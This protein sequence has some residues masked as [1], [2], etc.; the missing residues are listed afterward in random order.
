VQRVQRFAAP[1]L[2]VVN[3]WQIR[4]AALAAL[5]ALVLK[6]FFSRAYKRKSQ[7]HCGKTVAANRS[8]LRGAASAASAAPRKLAKCD[9]I[10]QDAFK[11]SSATL[12]SC[13]QK[14][15]TY[16]SV[17]VP[18]QPTSLAGTPAKIARLGTAHLS[19]EHAPSIAHGATSQAGITTELQP[20]AAWSPIITWPLAPA[21]T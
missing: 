17:E 8:F 15:A 3:S 11:E 10:A 5:A 7:R 16:A 13:E 4:I 9:R 21:R 19:N 14:N 2:V 12:W 20:M 1:R 6:I 18:R